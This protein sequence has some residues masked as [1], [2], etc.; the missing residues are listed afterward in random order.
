MLWGEKTFMPVCEDKLKAHR[1]CDL[2]WALMQAVL[3]LP[4][5]RE[6][7][8]QGMREVPL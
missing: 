3:A 2:V 5:G 1:V 7:P 6:L 8:A 4:F